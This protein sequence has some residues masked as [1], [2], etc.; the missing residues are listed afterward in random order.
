MRQPEWLIAAIATAARAQGKRTT[1]L[2]APL[3]ATFGEPFE[4]HRARFR[5]PHGLRWL[6]ALS[7]EFEV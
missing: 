5:T 1:R 6:A 4:G 2:P 7:S 3:V